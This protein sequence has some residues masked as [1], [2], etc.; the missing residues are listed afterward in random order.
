MCRLMLAR[1]HNRFYV[2]LM[3]VLPCMVDIRSKPVPK[4]DMQKREET[5]ENELC[6]NYPRL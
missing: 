6:S 2:L 5:H 1:V 3:L 4:K